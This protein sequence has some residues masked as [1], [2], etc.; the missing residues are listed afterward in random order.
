VNEADVVRKAQ[1]RLE[2][3]V[4]GAALVNRTGTMDAIVTSTALDVATG[5]HGAVAV[6]KDEV[7]QDGVRPVRLPLAFMVAVTA[8]RLHVFAI[9]MALGR[10]R[11][12]EQLAALSRDALTVS[13]EQGG[14]TTVFRVLGPG[15][16]RLMVFEILTSDYA[17]EFAQ[18]LGAPVHG[19]TEADYAGAARRRERRWIWDIVRRVLVTL[20]VLAFL[21]AT[22][23]TAWYF[24][25]GEGPAA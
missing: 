3:P 8:T 5:G 6:P 20:L 17:R 16:R 10:L 23:W 12:K 14:M 13:A 24:F 2:D 19:A 18:V 9:G 7:R 11:V 1:E 25:Y 21:A 4:L 22:A 15:G